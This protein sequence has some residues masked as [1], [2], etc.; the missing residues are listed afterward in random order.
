M[1]AAMSPGMNIHYKFLGGKN[2][3]EEWKANFQ[4]NEQTKV[5][6][7]GR[8]DV[9]EFFSNPKNAIKDYG[10]GVEFNM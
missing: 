6:V 10:I 7:S 9:G 1:T 8:D 4:V 3:V 2:W 5:V